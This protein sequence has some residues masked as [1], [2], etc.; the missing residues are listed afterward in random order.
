MANSWKYKYGDNEIIV[1][2]KGFN[3][4]ELY[5]NG[6]LQDKIPVGGMYASRLFGKLESGEEI[7]VS[8]GGFLKMQCCL[9]IDNK[10]QSE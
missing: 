10:L 6:E 9:F 3:G 5:V 4:E 8:V 2:N 7:K 1:K